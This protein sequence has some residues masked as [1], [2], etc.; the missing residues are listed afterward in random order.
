M[1]TAWQVRGAVHKPM[2]D[3]GKACVGVSSLMAPQRG[4]SK[5]GVKMD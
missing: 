1:R 4:K 3:G 2:A 5:R